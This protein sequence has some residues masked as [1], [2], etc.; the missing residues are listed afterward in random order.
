MIKHNP[1]QI[2]KINQFNQFDEFATKGV[3][4]GLWEFHKIINSI[5]FTYRI[6]KTDYDENDINPP[7]KVRDES[8][9]FQRL[10]ADDRTLKIIDFLIYEIKNKNSIVTFPTSFIVS[11]LTS[12]LNTK[13]DYI[14]LL[15]QSKKEDFENENLGV[16]FDKDLNEIILPEIDL[17]LI[18]DGQHRLAALKILYYSICLLQGDIIPVDTIGSLEK[19]IKSCTKKIVSNDLDNADNLIKIRN[20]IEDF[21]FCCTI[22]LD[23]DIWEQGKVFADVNFNQKPVNRSLYY[24]IYGSFPNE[25]KNEIFLLHKWCVKLNSDDDSYLKNKINLLGN[26][27]GFISQAFLCDALLPFLRSGGVWYKIANDFTLDRQDSSKTIEKFLKAYFNAISI[28]FGN[29][30][31]PEKY[32]WPSEKD[33]PRVF[34][35]ILLKTTGLGALI[36]LIPNFYN[37]VNQDLNLDLK[38]LQEKI[39]KIFDEKLT[40][41]ELEKIYLGN[42]EKMAL[43]ERKISGDYYFSKSQGGFSGGA[44]K[45]LQGKLYKELLKDFN[46]IRIKEKDQFSLFN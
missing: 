40:R 28:K 26:G 25:D 42:D 21:N 39:I 7:K 24:D 44:G 43:I 5:R 38:Q 18:V 37:L 13:K 10:V 14:E 9:Y 19:V 34:D 41:E 23:F 22:L 33:M 4:L 45:G 35:S 16:F 20:T 11:L 46:F 29:K 3:Y 8:D 36:G 32:F 12:E 27:K 31:N 6:P 1:L 30:R 17:M 15:N 2:K